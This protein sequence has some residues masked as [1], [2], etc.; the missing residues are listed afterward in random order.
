MFADFYGWT[1][2]GGIVGDGHH[3]DWTELWRWIEGWWCWLLWVDLDVERL[4]WVDL[5]IDDLLVDVVMLDV[6]SDFFDNLGIAVNSSDAVM[7]MAS[8]TFTA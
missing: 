2:Q 7:N 1:P 5:D 8:P 4:D 3:I 6:E